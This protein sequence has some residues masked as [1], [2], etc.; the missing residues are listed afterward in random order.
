[1]QLTFHTDYALRLLIYLMKRPGQQV[2]TREI[3]EHYGISVNHLVKV[4][5]F[6]TQKGWLVASRGSGGGVIMAD[7]TPKVKVGE[8]VRR[9]ENIDVVECFN[10]S[11]NT[12]PISRYCRLKPMLH[13]ARD[14]FLSVL[15]SFTVEEMALRGGMEMAGPRRRKKV[16][17]V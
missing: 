6:L 13:Q 2:S 3:A 10:A 8:I 1:V 7:H 12:C 4:A 14:A 9:L 16:T 5:K 17:Q 15:D 11:T